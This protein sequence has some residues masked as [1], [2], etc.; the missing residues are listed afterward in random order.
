MWG[1][2]YL[3]G[4]LVEAFGSLVRHAAQERFNAAWNGGDEDED[5]EEEWRARR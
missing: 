5:D 2:L 4:A 1:A 3:F